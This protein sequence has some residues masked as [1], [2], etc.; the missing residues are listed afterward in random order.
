MAFASAARRRLLISAALAALAGFPLT[1][2][3][4]GAEP[5]A[6]AAKEKATGP[7][8]LRKTE[9]GLAVAVTAA[10][11]LSKDKLAK[12]APFLGDAGDA[13]TALSKLADA[14]EKK[15]DQA[16]GKAVSA[17]S[18]AVGTVNA[19]FKRAAIADPAVKEGMR[20]FNASWDKTLKKLGGKKGTPESRQANGRRIHAAKTKIDDLR[21]RRAGGGGNAD[22]DAMLA[23]I[24]E[25]LDNAYNLN[26]SDDYDWLALLG[27]DDAFGWYDGYYGYLNA[28]DPAL[29]AYYADDYGYWNGLYN[30]YAPAY[31]TFY[32]GY[33][34]AS[35]N[36]S[37]DITSNV[38]VNVNI[39]SNEIIQEAD[40]QTNNLPQ[41]A[42]T[43]AEGTEGYAPYEAAEK[44]A[45]Q[46]PAPAVD[47]PAATP[48]PVVDPET[49]APLEP[50]AEE[51]LVE[52][53][54]GVEDE[55]V[56][57]TDSDGDGIPDQIDTDDD[58]DGIPDMQDPDDNGDGV[59]DA[60]Q[61][62]SDHDGIANAEDTDDDNDGIPDAEDTDDD[63]DGVPDVDDSDD[64]GGED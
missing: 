4:A 19:A 53:Q 59:A 54:E 16:L 39:V 58:N 61:E 35:Y 13:A 6:S 2:S 49:A 22:E 46:A 9:R 12:A 29:A 50:A 10:S 33:D 36:T 45:E 17:A 48:D 15:D 21:K 14:V 47:D 24:L 52:Q 60:E 11:K 43:A 62:D 23:Y 64:G 7:E 32:S 28:Y 55:A 56:D 51:A 40:T 63:G 34:F 57:A 38:N 31:D 26:R 27:L 20:A 18:K 25:L 30:D 37:I 1:S 44:A 5:A 42:A 8:L 41:L 3:I